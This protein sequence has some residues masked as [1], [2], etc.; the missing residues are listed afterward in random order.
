MFNAWRFLAACAVVALLTLAPGCGS[1]ET[2]ASNSP[3]E[4][5]QSPDDPATP[6]APTTSEAQSADSAEDPL[7]PIVVIE[8]SL[9]NMKVKLDAEKADMTV[10]NFLRYVDS[11]HYNG[12]IFHEVHQGHV[13]IG[14]AYT[15]ELEE[16]PTDGPIFN[17]A[18]DGRKNLR[19]TIAMARKPD[20]IDSATCH[21]FINLQDHPNLDHAGEKAEEYGYC[22]F[23]EV[24]DGMDVA[25][26]IGNVAVHDT[27]DF[28]Q[29]PVENVVI[30]SIRKMD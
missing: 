28:E 18:M 9:G 30:K 21:F 19:G 15:S 20:V 23:G 2:G 17:Q 12:T 24:I 1:Q 4:S 29:I 10:D 13:I 16:K 25:D 14:G 11:G 7:H 8:T 26:K 5:G 27:T 3:Q 22:V 6:A